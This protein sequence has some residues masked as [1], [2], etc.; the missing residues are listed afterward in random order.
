MIKTKTRSTVLIKKIRFFRTSGRPIQ[1]RDFPISR[2][3]DHPHL[4]LE[5]LDNISAFGK[6]PI[7]TFTPT[8]DHSHFS[9]AIS[10]EEED[11]LLNTRERTAELFISPPPHTTPQNQKPRE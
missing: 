1:R 9:L 7:E 2:T 6:I 8:E 11:E 5:G 3:I 10:S 4:L